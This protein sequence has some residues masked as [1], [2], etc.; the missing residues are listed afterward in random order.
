MEELNYYNDN[1][2]VSC[3]IQKSI[4]IFL[5]IKN[6]ILKL[7]DHI[8][9]FEDKKYLSLLLGIKYTNN[10]VSDILNRF[11]Y[12][13]GIQVHTQGIEKDRKREVYNEYFKDLLF[14]LSSLQSIEE[15]MLK[16][17]DVPFILELHN[18]SGYSTNKIKNVIKDKNDSK[19]LIKS[20]QK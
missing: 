13:Y 12:Y 8:V 19:I 14:D 5:M 9:S 15:L 4:E 10:G 6:T 16:L 2:E 18:Y 7:N 3:A 11:R 20:L 17:L 1:L